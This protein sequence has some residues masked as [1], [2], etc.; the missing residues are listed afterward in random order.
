M[1]PAHAVRAHHATRA[2]LCMRTMCHAPCCA[3]HHEPCNM[4]GQHGWTCWG[5]KRSFPTRSRTYHASMTRLHSQLRGCSTGAATADGAAATA[6]RCCCCKASARCT[7]QWS[8]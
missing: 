1:T 4:C 7:G 3:W 2:M 6:A 5:F 8:T